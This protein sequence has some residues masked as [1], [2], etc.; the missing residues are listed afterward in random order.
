MRQCASQL[1]H[2]APALP[3]AVIS[4]TQYAVGIRRNQQRRTSISAGHRLVQAC[5]RI[6]R[7]ICTDDQRD[8][9]THV[10]Q[11]VRQPLRAAR[12]EGLEST[13][14]EHHVDRYR[15]GRAKAQSVQHGGKFVVHQ[16]KRLIAFANRCF[17][18]ADDGNRRRHR[19]L[20]STGQP[21]NVE[22]RVEPF[23][24]ERGEPRQPAQPDS[25]QQD[26]AGQ[27]RSAP[28]AP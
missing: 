26:R 22:R 16:C 14:R 24:I 13:R 18:E 4:T 15:A 10:A 28:A 12:D 8:C 9:G 27:K 11:R 2:A 25:Q 7:Q 6:I 19:C 21:Q 5:S 17:I 23:E 1:R 3:K 20:L